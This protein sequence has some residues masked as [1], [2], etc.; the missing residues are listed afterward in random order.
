MSTFLQ[1]FGP[2]VPPLVSPVVVS[3][4]VEVVASPVDSPTVVG[5]TVEVT[6]GRGSPL[7][8]VV[9]VVAVESSP[10]P[11]LDEASDAGPVASLSG[12][13]PEPLG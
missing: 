12:S 11:S 8:D 1:D 2:P 4:E 10:P 7:V 9:L 5:S 6:P 13:L 3:P